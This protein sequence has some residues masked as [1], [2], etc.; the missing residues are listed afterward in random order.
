MIDLDL[1]TRRRCLQITQA[2]I[3]MELPAA[4]CPDDSKNTVKTGEYV[5]IA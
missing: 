3:I 5:L 1:H 2:E 4:P